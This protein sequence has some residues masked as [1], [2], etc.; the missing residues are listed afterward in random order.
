MVVDI[1]YRAFSKCNLTMKFVSI[2]NM[3]IDSSLHCQNLDWE[4]RIITLNG[5]HEINTFKK[6]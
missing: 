5:N 4:L 1:V 2:F 3:C 6:K